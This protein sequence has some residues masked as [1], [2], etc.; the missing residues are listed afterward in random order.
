[1]TVQ[2]QVDNPMWFDKQAIN[3]DFVRGYCQMDSYQTINVLAK[4]ENITQLLIT[5]NQ[6]LE[7]ILP[8]QQELEYNSNMA[9]AQEYNRKQRLAATQEVITN[10]E[11]E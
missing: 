5:Q 2:D 8:S 9:E 7:K 6:L 3:A 11:E 1:M 4:L 10:V